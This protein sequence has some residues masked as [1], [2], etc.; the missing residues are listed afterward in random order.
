MHYAFFFFCPSFQQEHNRVQQSAKF[1]ISVS[2]TLLLLV[3]KP[4]NLALEAI[5]AYLFIEV[6]NTKLAT[7]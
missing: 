2:L 1:G 6:S 4:L 7:S 5:S 3:M